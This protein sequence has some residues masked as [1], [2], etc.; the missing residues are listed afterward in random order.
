[1]AIATTRVREG[2]AELVVPNRSLTDPHHELAFYNPRMALNRSV[3]SLALG[4][5]LPSLYGGEVLDGLCSLGARGLRYLLE[6]PAVTR[7]TFVDA[8]DHALPL[9]KRNLALNKIPRRKYRVEARDLNIALAN[10]PGRFDAVE[11]DPFGSP[12]LY[13]ESVLR[14]L[15]KRALLSIT[16]TDLANLFGAKPRPAVRHYDARPLRTE[17]GHELALRILLG[18]IARSAAV[19]EYAA[20]P[21]LSFFEGHAAKAIVRV[22]RSAPEADEVLKT[23]GWVSHCPRCL[24]REAARL[25]KEECPSCGASYEHAGPLWLGALGE[26]AFLEAVERENRVRHYKDEERIGKLLAALRE[27]NALPLGFYDLHLLARRA[28]GR[29]PRTSAVVE[30][31]RAQ[32]FRAS[33][34]HV[35]PLGVKTDARAGEVL[36]VVRALAR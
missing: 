26:G 14:R 25:P 1:M 12:A 31:L 7:V 19:Y 24:H 32:G 22:E 16:A 17:Y 33:A 5:A 9:L 23:M 18:R 21:L 4:C 20:K 29:V 27:E 36:K 35:S 34:T 10:S 3:S 8:N 30:S 11:L 2:A 15:N 13:L 28:G 6:N